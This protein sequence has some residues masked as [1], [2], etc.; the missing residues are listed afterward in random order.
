MSSK[1]TGGMGACAGGAALFQLKNVRSHS[2][3]IELL[4]EMMNDCA[5]SKVKKAKKSG[6]MPKG[7]RAMSGYNCFMR[8][9]GIKTKDFKGCLTAKGWSKLPD[10]EKAKYNK[11]AKEGCNIGT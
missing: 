2:G 5:K 9:C 11:W 6:N 1:K 10:N 4:E 7:K 3:K 8:E